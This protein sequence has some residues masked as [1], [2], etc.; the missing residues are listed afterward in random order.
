[1]DNKEFHVLRNGINGND[2][3]FTTID[4]HDYEHRGDYNWKVSEIKRFIPSAV[5]VNDELDGSVMH[6][7]ISLR[8]KDMEK[9]LD[10]FYK[11]SFRDKDYN[12]ISIADYFEGYAKES[13]FENYK[14]RLNEIKV[15]ESD[16]KLAEKVRK[17]KK[18]ELEEKGVKQVDYSIGF[19]CYRNEKTNENYVV[20]TR[21]SDDIIGDLYEFVILNKENKNVMIPKNHVQLYK[22]FTYFQISKIEEYLSISLPTM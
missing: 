6:I 18:E 5:V 3:V 9:A 8:A 17:L 14:G 20:A 15:A 22:H 2:F 13:E 12:H 19:F 16:Y 1:M 10:R 21:W 7:T 11:I 4:C